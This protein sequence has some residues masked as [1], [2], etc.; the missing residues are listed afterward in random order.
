MEVIYIIQDWVTTM[1]DQASYSPH[2]RLGGNYSISRD[3]NKKE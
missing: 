3:L 2:I 1:M